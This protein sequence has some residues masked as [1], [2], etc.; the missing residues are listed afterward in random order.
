LWPEK[1][2]TIVVDAVSARAAGSLR[3]AS[4]NSSFTRKCNRLY[5]QEVKINSWAVFV[6]LLLSLPPGNAQKSAA[7]RVISWSPLRLESGSP[8]FF[9]VELDQPAS[10]LRGTWLKHEI[11]F[12]RAQEDNRWYALAGIDVE[13]APG[14]YILELTASA[15]DG[16][17][18][19]TKQ[20]VAVLPAHYKTTTLHVE[21]KYV[22]PDAATLQHIAADKA[23]KDAAYAH[24]ASEPLWNGSFRSPVP[25]TATDSFGTRRMFN[26]ELASIH[27]GTDFHAPSGTPV[28]AANDGQVII[29]CPMFYEGNLVVIDHGQQFMTQY[30]HLSKIDVKV[31]DRVSKGQR[32]GL[33]GATGRVTGPHLHLGARWGGESVDP[34]ILLRLPLPTR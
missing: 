31:G 29:A 27:R 8:V 13:Q 18:L 11:V 21:E 33:S 15:T 26:G 5:A 10:A 34:V 25:F 6:L 16:R 23:V 1:D 32:L 28:L 17:P 19:Q 3:D 7:F 24:L 2:T 12:T 9:K 30:M 14:N 22:Q 20:E 4:S